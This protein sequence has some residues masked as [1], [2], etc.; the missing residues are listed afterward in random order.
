MDLQSLFDNVRQWAHD[1]GI[2]GPE[3]RGTRLKQLEKVEEE[4]LETKMAVLAFR[5]AKNPQDQWKLLDEIE[6]GI[7]DSIVTLIILAEMH[8]LSAESCL[9]SAYRVIS[10]RTGSMIDGQFIK[11][12]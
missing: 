10:K 4:I 6:D 3:G 7:G 2:T 8:G 1:K 11:D 12:K 5:E 9:E